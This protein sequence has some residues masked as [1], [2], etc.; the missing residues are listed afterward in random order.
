ME[1][2]RLVLVGSTGV[3]GTAILR[4]ARGI[5]V[6]ALVRSDT[7]R[8]GDHPCTKVLGALPDVPP[9][10]FP[11]APHVL[12]H[13]AG[14]TSDRTLYSAVNVEGTR[15]LMEALS[16]SCL[17]VI[18]GSSLSVVG[19]GAQRRVDEDEAVAPDTELARSRAQAERIVLEG[20]AKRGISAFVLRPRFLLGD[21]DQT[22]LPAMLRFARWGVSIGPGTQE[23]SVIDLDDYAAIVVALARRIVERAE[24]GE[25][26]QT[27][28][29]VGYAQPISFDAIHTALAEV[30][31]LPA[32]KLRIPV[33]PRLTRALVRVPVVS[34][35]ATK[36]ALVGLDHHADVSRLSSE[37]GDAIVARDPRH[38]VA[39]VARSL[40]RGLS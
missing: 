29:H 36:L 38:V 22:T 27:P 14:A 16:P 5:E 32:R 17:G 21:G 28:L 19:S 3:T 2:L 23:F 6:R 4:A 37:I 34:D 39:R 40:P 1:P 13:F 24:L 20:A 9:T 33:P 7:A 35:V 12:L 26:V 18:Y 30:F 31:L 10:L 8:L 25:P 15:A 11:D